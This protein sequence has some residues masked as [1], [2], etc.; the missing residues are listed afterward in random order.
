MLDTAGTI[1]KR[2]PGIRVE[3]AGHTDPR[4]IRTTEFPSNWE[5]SEARAEAVRRYLIDRF[6]I[7]PERLTARGYAD[8]QPVAD[9][10]T[11]QGMAR[12]RR[13]EFRVISR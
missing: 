13:T 11:P 3:L 2:T 12:N 4:E 7:A 10:S 1:L 5:L 9:N 6:D 8:T